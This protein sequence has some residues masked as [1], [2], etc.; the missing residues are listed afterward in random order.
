MKPI[1][2]KLRENP[3]LYS[4]LKKI[5]GKTIGMYKLKELYAKKIG[6]FNGKKRVKLLEKEEAEKQISEKIKSGKPFMLGRFGSTEFR[7]LTQEG[8]FDLLYF[9]S[10]F[11]P[12]DPSLLEKFRKVYM[13][14]AKKL[15]FMVIWNYK[16]HFMKKI[17]LLRKLPDVKK[18]IPL[19]AIGRNNH[20]WL[21]SLEGRRI[22]VVHPFKKTIE[23]QMEKRKELGILP[24]LKK[25]EVIKAVQTLAN[26]ED[27]RFKDWFEALEYMKKQI[28]KKDFDIAIIGC[29]AYGLPLA[30]YVKSKGKQSLHLAGSSQLLFGIKGKR[31]EG[32]IPMNKHWIRPLKEDFMQNYDKIEKGCYW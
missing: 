25:L 6:F 16:N 7:N 23:K 15:D 19:S 30:S 2:K 21:K 31:W 32:K 27:N 20:K 4:R 1:L 28:D 24:K 5:Y 11:F 29:G 17:K 14:A 22:L 18:L 13:E 26:N 8:Q 12:K 10:G 9:Y 3:E